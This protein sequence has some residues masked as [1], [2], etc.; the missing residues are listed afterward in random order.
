MENQDIVVYISNDCSQCDELVSQLDEWGVKYQQKNTTENAN[1]LK[2][3][4]KQKIYA[5]PAVFIG[6]QKIL[7]FQ[8]N[9]LKQELGIRNHYSYGN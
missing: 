9:K 7:G 2:D 1:F 4:Q 5:T 6:N 3:L 8:K